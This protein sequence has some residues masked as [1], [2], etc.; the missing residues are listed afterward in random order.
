MCIP[1]VAEACGN[2]IR[3]TRSSYRRTAHSSPSAPS[4]G[5]TGELQHTLNVDV[6]SYADGR[7]STL[8]AKDGSPEGAADA[9]YVWR[10]FDAGCS[11]RMLHPQRWCDALWKVRLSVP[12]AAAALSVG[13]RSRS[14]YTAAWP[15][16][17]CHRGDG[18]A[19]SGPVSRRCA[20]PGAALASGTH[21]QSSL[22]LKTQLSS[23]I[24]A[25]KNATPMQIIWQ[26]LG[27]LELFFRAP[28]GCNA[29]LT[30][31]GRQGFAPH[32]DDID[33]FILQLEGTKRWVL[34]NFAFKP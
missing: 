11:V 9:A 23:V 3:M 17:I 6:T 24:I 2:Y 5:R 7:R 26:V 22:Q 20:L 14:F 34:A 15:A 19:G 1:A 30:P 28:V 4:T 16:P 10:H 27:T 33:A 25:P 12:R 18:V 29:Y 13:A 31:P 8:P 21:S 32:S